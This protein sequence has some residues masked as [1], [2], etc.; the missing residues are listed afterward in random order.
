MFTSIDKYLLHDL[1]LLQGEYVKLMKFWISPNKT[2]QGYALITDY[3]VFLFRIELHNMYGVGNLYFLIM[4]GY[5]DME[6]DKLNFSEIHAGVLENIFLM[7]TTVE[8]NVRSE[9]NF[10]DIESSL[11]LEFEANRKYLV[12]PQ[13]GSVQTTHSEHVDEILDQMN[14]YEL[15]ESRRAERQ[16]TFP[17]L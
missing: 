17:L 8:H 16:F 15:S 6:L 5:R 11:L 9:K 14:K 1:Y 12:H 2:N 7:K 3:A 13:E 10:V 4:N